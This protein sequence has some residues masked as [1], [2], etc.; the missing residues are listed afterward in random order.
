VFATVTPVLVG[1]TSYEIYQMMRCL[2][3][4]IFGVRCPQ[5]PQAIAAR[6]TGGMLAVLVVLYAGSISWLVASGTVYTIPTDMIAIT[7]LVAATGLAARHW[8]G[9][10]ARCR[11]FADRTLGLYLLHFPLLVLVTTLAA[12][13]LPDM[14]LSSSVAAAMFVVFAGVAAA[15]L[16][17]LANEILMRIGANWLFDVPRLRSP[18]ALATEAAAAFARRRR[19]TEAFCAACSATGRSMAASCASCAK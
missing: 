5:I 10:A 7:T 6:A 4:F 19:A 13:F 1:E 14:L 8:P 12:R 17:L 16:A 3:Y 15:L 9:F 11:W 2:P 18:G